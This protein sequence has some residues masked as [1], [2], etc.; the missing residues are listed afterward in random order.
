MKERKVALVTGGS[1]GIGEAIV[2]KFAKEGFWVCFSYVKS[3]EKAEKLANELSNG[4]QRVI[5]VKADAGNA[6]EIKQLVKTCAETFGQIDV[7]VNNA[8]ISESGLLVDMTD[9]QIVNL[10]NVNL[11][12]CI[13][14]TR[15]VIKEMLKRNY[16]KIVN[17]SSIWGVSGASCESV[18][19]A[20]K[21]GIIGFTQ[22]VAK[23]FGPSNIN[24]NAVAP[25]VIGTDML[26]GYTK[27]EIQELVDNT[28]LGR[29][30]WPEDIAN[31]VYFLASDDARF[32]TGQCLVV[33]GGFLQ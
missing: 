20:S 19:S 21:A 10:L 7:L 3:Q 32:I 6:F 9:E 5:A 23:E 8:G 33:D 27:Q 22:G 29:I 31:A 25:G 24:V 30:G 12:S 18:Y 28:A 17:I 16:G 2:R 14:T 1:R 26:K 15:E 11:N 13:I 4:E